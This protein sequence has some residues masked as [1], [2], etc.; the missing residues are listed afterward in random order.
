[1]CQRSKRLT[2]TLTL[3]ATATAEGRQ[4]NGAPSPVEGGGNSQVLAPPNWRG[5]CVPQLA[6]AYWQ[7]LRTANELSAVPRQTGGG[8]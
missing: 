1:M 8:M 7:V 4:L 6:L 2:P 3:G 5:Y